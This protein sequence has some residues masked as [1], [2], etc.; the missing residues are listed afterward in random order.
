VPNGSEPLNTRS[1]RTWRKGWVAIMARI[2]WLPSP[3]RRVRSRFVNCG[4][5]LARVARLQSFVGRFIPSSR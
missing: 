5:R 1:S 2:R 3:M 4:A